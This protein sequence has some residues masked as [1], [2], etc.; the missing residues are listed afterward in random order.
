METADYWYL[1]TVLVFAAILAVWVYRD[2]HKFKRESIFLLRRTQRGRGTL[3]KIGTSFPRFWKAVGFVSVT[4]GFIVSVL[5]LK[6]LIDNLVAAIAAGAAVPSLALL[7]PSPTTQPILGYGYLAVPFWYWIICIAIL[8]VVHEGF[9]GIFT[10]R[11]KTKIKSLGFGLLAVIPLAFVEPDERQLEK[12]GTWPQLRVFSAGSFANFLLALLSFVL[13][14]MLT[15]A[16]FLPA[17]VDFQTYP[18]ATIGL[19]DINW[20]GGNAVKGADDIAD[21]LHDY[22]EN[23]TV[24][25]RTLDGIYYLRRKYFDEQLEEG[26]TDILVFQN[27]PAAKAGIEG[28]IVRVGDRPIT[29]QLDLSIALEEAGENRSVEIAVM[30]GETEK[31]YSIVTGVI[32]QL[33]E[34]SPDTMMYVSAAIEHVVPGTIDAQESFGEWLEGLA[35]YRTG[36]TWIYLNAK[37]MTWEWIGG[38]Y[39]MLTERAGEKIRGLETAMEGRNRPGFMGI[40]NVLPHYELRA[41]MEPYSGATDFIQGLLMFLFIINLG[42][43]IV[44]LLPVKPLDGGK[45]WDVVLKRYAPKHANMIMRVMG[46][47]ILALLLAN[48]LPLGALF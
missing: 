48:F 23:E 8:A 21:A 37:K 24:E 38:N 4:V 28:T 40:L 25:I 7:L 42:V 10:A 6:M 45:M 11:E 47:L 30:E 13:F 2:R 22:G 36:D 32:P 43:G 34:Y 41:G 33:A 20:I 27:Y 3:I 39:P 16:I 17:G 31:T 1:L 46:Y 29:D 14:L 5:G 26:K 12:K 18:F 19:A 15:S 9:H 44:N 35:C